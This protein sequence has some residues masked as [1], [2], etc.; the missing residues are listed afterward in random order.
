MKIYIAGPITK[1]PNYKKRFNEV[2]EFLEEKGHIVLNPA[3]LPPGME[4]GEYMKICFAMIDVADEAH[5]MDGWE[6][7]LGANLEHD[8]CVYCG[9]SVRLASG[10]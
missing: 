6:W 8:Y 3:L 7:S 4:P 9:K 1:E 10:F 2:Q 5:F